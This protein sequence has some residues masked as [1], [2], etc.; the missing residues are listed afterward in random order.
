MDSTVYGCGGGTSS[1]TIRETEFHPVNAS[2][3][4]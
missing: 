1:T 4:P 2:A 3:F